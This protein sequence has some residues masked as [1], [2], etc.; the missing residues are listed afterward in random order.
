M[1]R[2]DPVG[3]HDRPLQRPHAAHRPAEHG[4]ELRDAE[5]VGQRD[6]GRDLVAHGDSAETASRRAGRRGRSTTGRWCPGSRRAR[7]RRATKSRSVSSGAPGPISPSHQ[8]GVGCSGPAGPTTCESPVSACSTSTA[9]SRAAFSSPQVSY[10]TVTSAARAGLG[11]QRADVGV[12][13]GGD[14]V[15]AV[16]ASRRSTVPPPAPPPGR[17]GSAESA[18]AGVRAGRRHRGRHGRRMAP[19]VSRTWRPRSPP[20]GRP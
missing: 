3:L 7:W 14:A 19:A 9:L 20:R 12:P 10:A 6:L 2:R 18:G 8:P 17:S 4:S 13:A 1:Q 5:V 11:C 15:G 16:G